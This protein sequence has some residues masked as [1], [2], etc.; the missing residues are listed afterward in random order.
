[1]D[2]AVEV[3]QT[4]HPPPPPHSWTGS[5]PVHHFILLIQAQST[6]LNRGLFRISLWFEIS[7]GIFLL[8][9]TAPAASASGVCL[10]RQSFPGDAFCL[11]SNQPESNEHN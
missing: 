5:L 11:V 2:W 8:G 7:Q 4:Q 6:V 1:M 9:I 3:P 10:S